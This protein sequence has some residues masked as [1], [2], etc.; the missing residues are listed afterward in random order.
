MEGYN[1]SYSK[2][3]YLCYKSF[4]QH[5]IDFGFEFLF[6]FE[7]VNKVNEV[8]L[9]T[10]HKILFNEKY[11]ILCHLSLLY[12]DY[13][14]NEKQKYC[15]NS[16]HLYFELE[17]KLINVEYDKKSKP[18][19]SFKKRIGCYDP[20]QF[21]SCHID[22]NWHPGNS[23]D[24][25]F[26]IGEIIYYFEKEEDCIFKTKWVPDQHDFEIELGFLYLTNGKNR[27]SEFLEKIENQNIKIFLTNVF[28]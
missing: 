25:P 8:N 16:C 18:Y 2:G 11:C 27:L 21:E 10:L 26:E 19:K 9:I 20:S 4:Y 7:K 14:T 22:Y 3:L 13:E 28:K 6:E 17:R 23:E 15:F 1:R 5:L 12:R 24:G